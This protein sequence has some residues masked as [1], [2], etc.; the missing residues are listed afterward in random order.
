MFYLFPLITVAIWAGNAIVNKMA[1]SVI[2]PGAISFYRWFFAL[3]VLTPFVAK[4]VWRDR[5]IIK[6][7]LTKLA[8]LGL[9]GMVLNQSLGYFAAATTTATNIALIISLVPLI[10]MFLSVPILGQRLSPFALIGAVLSLSGLVLMLSHGDVK[11]LISQGIKQGDMLMLIA[12]AVYALYCV[13]LKRWKMPFSTWKSVYVQCLFAVVMLTP[14]LLMSHRM[15]IT[16]SAVPLIAYAALLASVI[17]PWLWMLSIERLGAD[18]TAMFMNLL[19]IM[20]A[21]IASVMLNE[22]LEAYHYIGGIMVLT[23]VALA[24]KRIKAKKQAA[25][26]TTA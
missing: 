15:A 12:A 2:D 14:L 8:F 7:Y 9:L 3:V 24:Q 21:G 17:A 26:M 22:H 20:A 13:L 25:A 16:A 4:S 19:P 23:G 1:F 6:P 18:R 10:S 11:S 5:A